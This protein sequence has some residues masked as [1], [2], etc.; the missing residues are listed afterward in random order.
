MRKKKQKRSFVKPSRKIRTIYGEEKLY[1]TQ[2]L[3]E[4]LGMK[5]R[6]YILKLLRKEKI[7]II[8]AGH[9]TKLVTETDFKRFLK[10]RVEKM[11]K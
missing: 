11:L 10:K 2:E 7:R 3:S 6:W 1:T 4:I 8:S 9:R 5:T